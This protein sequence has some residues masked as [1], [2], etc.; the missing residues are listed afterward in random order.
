MAAW[1]LIAV[2]ATGLGIVAAGSAVSQDREAAYTFGDKRSG[3][4]YSLALFQTMQDDDFANP[5]FL[6]IDQGEENW[7]EVEGAAGK[8]CA[9]CHQ[10]VTKTM[11]GVGA[12]YPKYNAAKKKVINLEQRINL[13]RTDNMKAK[14]W[15]YESSQ[16]LAMTAYVRHQSRGMPVSVSI[17]GPARPFY[18]KGKTFFT[19]R[20]GLFDMACTNCHVDNA[21]KMLRGNLLSQGHVNGFPTYRQGW[22]T[23]GS[24]HRMFNVCNIRLRAAV[25]PAGSDEYVNL[26]LYTT[27]RSKGLKIETPSVRR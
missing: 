17:D 23:L 16:L 20:A 25:Y 27:H 12:V 13:C 3:Y 2:V 15:K 9:S 19:R 24:L 4:L 10:D 6:W 22:Q 5:A 7:V 21:G 1:R 11:K 14:A 18:E 26:E 8:S